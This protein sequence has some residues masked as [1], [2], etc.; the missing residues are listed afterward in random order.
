MVRER[1]GERLPV[2]GWREWAVLPELAISRIKCKVDTGART[3]AL[4]AFFVET[5]CEGGRERV[6]FGIHPYQGRRD[7]ERL[8]NA[9]VIDHRMV[10]D[11]GGHREKRVFIRTTVVIGKLS[12]PVELSLTDR[13]TMRFRMLLGRTSVQ[14]RFLVDPARSYVAGKPL[15]K[16]SPNNRKAGL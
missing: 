7:I 4:H 2:L 6:R 12:W 16:D 10:T 15:K 14:G 3:S 9:E 8:C 1:S 13:D 5:F 11:S